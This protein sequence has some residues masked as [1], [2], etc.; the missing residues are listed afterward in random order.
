MIFG[1]KKGS[2]VGQPN[3]INIVWYN[4]QSI[5]NLPNCCKRNYVWIATITMIKFP[6]YRLRYNLKKPNNKSR[7]NIICLASN[8]FS[9]F[10]SEISKANKLKLL[11]A[12]AIHI[13]VHN[14]AAAYR[15]W[16]SV[17]SKWASE[18]SRM[19]WRGASFFWQLTPHMLLLYHTLTFFEKLLNWVLYIFYK[20][21]YFSP[22]FWF[23]DALR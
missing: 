8:F 12:T 6:L 14:K 16:P 19:V 4:R 1:K 22:Q 17:A 11:L 18:W 2:K 9:P 23:N 20:I 10:D 21:S 7:N 15:Y 3:S 13:S 5:F